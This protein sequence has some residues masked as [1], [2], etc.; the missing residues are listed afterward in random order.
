M[1]ASSEVT[2]TT[3][4]DREVVMTRVF[5]APR[6]LVFDAF[7]K[8]ELLM[9]WL[10]APGRSMVTCEVDLRVGGAYRFVW[11]GPGKKDVGSYGEYREVIAPERFVRTEAWIDW[12]AGEVLVTTEFREHGQQTT[13]T[14]KALFPSRQVRDTVVEA[15]MKGSAARNYDRL[16]VLLA[17]RHPVSA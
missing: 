1:N 10:D 5:E 8:P 4:S 15:G 17:R 6:S 9:Q 3:P 12:D 14:I 2:I 7:T 13:V 11:S 16:A